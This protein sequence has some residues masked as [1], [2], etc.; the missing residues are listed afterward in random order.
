MEDWRPDM[1]AYGEAV[2]M[3]PAELV[4]ALRPILGD[5]LVAVLGH[6]QE[7]RAVR[8]WA[9]GER[10]ISSPETVERLRLAW[11]IVQLICERDTPD[12]AQAWMRGL[13]PLLEDRA[14]ALV[15]REGDL[16]EVGP[17]V[18]AAAREFAATG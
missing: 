7:T 5:R 16:A 13:N 12:V 14:P 18:L 8:Q 4:T 1:A 2:R 9:D 3:T 15:L 6:V 10:K 17:Q 11:R